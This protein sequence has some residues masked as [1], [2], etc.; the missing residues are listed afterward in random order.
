M[1]CVP[2]QK[3]LLL[4][5]AMYLVKQNADITEAQELLTSE[6]S[7]KSFSSCPLLRAYSGLFAYL[8]W[9]KSRIQLEK[10][11]VEGEDIDQK[12]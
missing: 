4:N 12:K 3:E 6:L 1:I 11:D 7:H 5:F 2:F 8:L 9:K 10:T